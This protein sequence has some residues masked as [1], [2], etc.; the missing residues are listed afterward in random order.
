MRGLA[1]NYLLEGSCSLGRSTAAVGA[2][3]VG[4]LEVVGGSL[5][6]G[7][8]CLQIVFASFAGCGGKL[9]LQA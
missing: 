2:T 3:F 8:N 5:A 9:L 6:A 1:Q 4:S 7:A